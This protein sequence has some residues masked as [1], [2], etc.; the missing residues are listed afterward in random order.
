M[1][2]ALFPPALAEDLTWTCVTPVCPL[3]AHPFAHPGSLGTSTTAVDLRNEALAWVD[4]TCIVD[5]GSKG[6][7]T[8]RESA[9]LT[10]AGA[11]VESYEY[12]SSYHP[13]SWSYEVVE[14]EVIPSASEALPWTDLRVYYELQ[15]S[16]EA[17]YG[18]GRLTWTAWW[19][20]SFR[21]DW[22]DDTAIAGFR[23][24]DHWLGTESLE[25]QEEG[26]DDGA[27]TWTAWA[28]S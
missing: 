8:C 28:P 23:T 14:I 4:K 2:F 9:C 7:V 11:W 10:S 1:L 16:S 21:K 18:G 6:D 17:S 19:D 5:C 12:H 25:H 20:G 13:T 24:W 15:S 3:D 26:W 22:P 27:C